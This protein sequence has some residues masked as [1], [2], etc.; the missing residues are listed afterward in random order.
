ML[1][2]QKFHH[3]DRVHLFLNPIAMSAKEVHRD[4]HVASN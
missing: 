1:A 3:N 4:W 2:E